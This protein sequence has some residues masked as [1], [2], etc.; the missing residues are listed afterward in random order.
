MN[1]SNKRRAASEPVSE[2]TTNR[3][4]V[5]LRAPGEVAALVHD[6][7]TRGGLVPAPPLWR[8]PRFWGALGVAA[9]A[10]AA[11]TAAIVLEPDVRTEVGFRW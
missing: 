9:A 1:S 5:Y 8:R 7:T 3:L 10:A 2:L 4:S 6:L 11:I